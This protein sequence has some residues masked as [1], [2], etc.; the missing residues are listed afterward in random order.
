[1]TREPQDSELPLVSIRMPAYNHERFVEAALDSALA[2]DY[3]NKELVIVDDGSTDSTADIIRAWIARHESE[4]PVTFLSHE[5][6]GLAATL[7]ELGDLC[8]GDILVPLASDDLLHPNGIRPRVDYLLAHPD[9]F[10]VMG[11][12]VLIDEEGRIVGKSALKE[13]NQVNFDD[14]QSDVGIRRDMIEGKPPPGPC[15]A[16]R[17]SL[18]DVVGGYDEKLRVIDD[19]DFYLR[20][21]AKDLLGYIDE[22]VGIYRI[23]GRNMSRNKEAADLIKLDMIRSVRRNFWLFRG[24]DQWLL[25]KRLFSLVTSYARHNLPGQVWSRLGASQG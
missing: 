11:D 22:T 13:L 18:Y 19:W 21:V 25:T 4:I 1:M 6:R 10:A 2:A 23:H 15:T 24:Y 5:N 17:K 12:A 16:V 7:N 14:Y 20:I 8:G 9:K 3:P